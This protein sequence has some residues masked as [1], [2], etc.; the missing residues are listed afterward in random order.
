MILFKLCLYLFVLFTFCNG[1]PASV[2]R[3]FSISFYKIP[4]SRNFVWTWKGKIWNHVS[5]IPSEMY[6]LPIWEQCTH[7]SVTCPLL[8]HYQKGKAGYRDERCS[9]I[10]L[11]KLTIRLVGVLVDGHR[12]T[13]KTC[14]K[15]VPIAGFWSIENCSYVCGGMSR[16]PSTQSGC[17]LSLISS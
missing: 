2:V 13:W 8:S 6:L 1:R 14:R 17:F 3:L 9:M 16:H 5:N 12:S 11:V 15:S 10:V 4:L 7:R